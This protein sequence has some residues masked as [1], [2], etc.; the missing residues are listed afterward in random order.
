MPWHPV[1]L[2]RASLV[3]FPGDSQA[4]RRMSALGQGGEPVD[5]AELLTFL[6]TPGAAGMTGQVI[7][8]CGGM[9]IGAW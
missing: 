4:G 9:F 2:K 1:L 8:A 6:S 5:A 7:R 3:Q